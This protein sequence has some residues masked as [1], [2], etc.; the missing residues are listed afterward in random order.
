MSECVRELS[1]IELIEQSDIKNKELILQRLKEQDY[2][3]DDR[4]KRLEETVQ[5]QAEL[6]RH[7]RGVLEDTVK[8]NQTGALDF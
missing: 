8:S 3:V 7:Y 6:I 2:W 1:A 4:I 5:A